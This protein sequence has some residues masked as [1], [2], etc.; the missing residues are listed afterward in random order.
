MKCKKCGKEVECV[1]C[2]GKEKGVFV[3]PHICPNV[4]EKCT[5]PQEDKPHDTC[6]HEPPPYPTDLP[7]G[8]HDIKCIKCGEVIATLTRETYT[9]KPQ[10]N[11]ERVLAEFEKFMH[12]QNSDGVL[13]YNYQ[14]LPH[15]KE[16]KAFLRTALENQRKEIIEEIKSKLPK[17]TELPFPNTGIFGVGGNINEF[18]EKFGYNKYYYEVTDLLNTLT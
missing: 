9:P 5:T 10:D 2:L 14:L 12:I 7:D 3:P 13:Y 4:H 18:Q 16:V 11:T 6:E 8:K 17:K 1:M 15:P